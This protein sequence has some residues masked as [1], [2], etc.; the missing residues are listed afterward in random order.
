MAN[1]RFYNGGN[2]HDLTI[3]YTVE[4]RNAFHYVRINA[5]DFFEVPETIKVSGKQYWTNFD[6]TIPTRKGL[7]GIIRVDKD[8][9]E[10][11]ATGRVARTDD[12]AR[13]LGDEIHQEYLIQIVQDYTNRVEAFRSQGF[14]P[15]P[16]QGYVKY[17][18]T[19]LNIEDP[20]EPVRNHVAKATEN[21]RIAAL[22]AQLKS[23]LSKKG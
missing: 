21:E 18:L 6:Q 22:E 5:K 23:L 2:A 14:N 1:F 17:A 7:F 10:T 3:P 19:T 9:E 12:E 15:L 4:D 13:K 11:A 16:A 20:A 8:V